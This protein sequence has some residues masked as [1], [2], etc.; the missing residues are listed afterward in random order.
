MDFLCSNHKKQVLLSTQTAKHYWEQWIDQGM[1]LMEEQSP[2][3]ALSFFGCSLDVA[4]W[5]VNQ[6]HNYHLNQLDDYFEKLTLSSFLT[7]ECCVQV[8]RTDLELHFLLQLHHRLLDNTK[9]QRNIFWPLAGYIKQSLE[10]IKAY[11]ETHG[12]FKGYKVCLIDTQ[13]QLDKLNMA[14]N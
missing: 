9:V 3:D 6:S 10:R 14:L 1:K 7:A 2:A 8:N 12:E 5:L 13:Q 4:D 11:V